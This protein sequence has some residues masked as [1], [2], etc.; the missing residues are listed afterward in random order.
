MP[1]TAAEAED[2]LKSRIASRRA[3]LAACTHRINE[4]KPLMVDDGNADEVNDIFEMFKVKSNQIKC[5]SS[6]H[7]NT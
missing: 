4:I 2:L 1:E 5:L 6:M 7:S 3:R